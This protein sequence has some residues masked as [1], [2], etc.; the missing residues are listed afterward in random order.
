M[1]GEDMKPPPLKYPERRKKAAMG[2]RLLAASDFRQVNGG[3]N[4]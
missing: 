1:I 3:S 2:L 4:Y